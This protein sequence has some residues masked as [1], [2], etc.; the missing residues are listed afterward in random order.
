MVSITTWPVDPLVKVFREDE[1]NSV[2]PVRIEAGRNEYENGQIALRCSEDA[3]ITLSCTPLQHESGS[4]RLQ[5]QPRFVGYVWVRENVRNTPPEEIIHKAPGEFPDYLI[6]DPTLSVKANQAQPIWL[7]VFVPEG[8]PVG[9]YS[10]Q[11]GVAANGKGTKVEVELLVHSATVNPAR[12]LFVT[13]WVNPGNI[14]KFAKLEAWSEEHWKLLRAHARSMANHRQ[15]VILTPMNL[16]QPK[17]KNGE[18]SFDFSR[19]DRWIRTFA[20]Q[21]VDGLIEGGI[22]AEGPETGNPGSTFLGGGFLRGCPR[23]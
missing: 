22:S 12:T 8:S 10:G 4:A 13:N 18:F 5:C 6:E 9:R 11:V 19:F 2:G 3:Q 20:E 1:P 23:P 15:N 14:A 17:R 21:G 7:T 16:I